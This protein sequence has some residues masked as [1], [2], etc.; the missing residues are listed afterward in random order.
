MKT[1]KGDSESVKKS[2]LP[3]EAAKALGLTQKAL[4]EYTDT[5][6]I[7]L[8]ASKLG[9]SA[10]H[11]SIKEL[12]GELENLNTDL[13]GVKDTLSSYL[14]E[15]ETQNK[16]RE[17]AYNSKKSQLKKAEADR[18]K[19]SKALS[20]TVDLAQKLTEKNE[21]LEA[22]VQSSVSDNQSM[23]EALNASTA[24]LKQAG[25]DNESLKTLIESQQAQ[26]EK[27]NQIIAAQNEIQSFTESKIASLSSEIN[28]LASAVQ[29]F[30]QLMNASNAQLKDDVAK[31]THASIEKYLG[32]MNEKVGKLTSVLAAIKKANEDSAANIEMH[33]TQV[34]EASETAKDVLV[35]FKQVVDGM[36]TLAKEV[37]DSTEAQSKRSAQALAE[38]TT[39]TGTVESRL[40]AILRDAPQDIVD[41]VTPIVNTIS[42]SVD[43]EIVDLK[44]A[45]EKAVNLGFDTLTSDV[46]TRLGFLVNEVNERTSE[47]YE[48]ATKAEDADN[49][50]IL[51][52]LESMASTLQEVSGS[53]AETD[54]LKAKLAEL[55]KNQE[56]ISSMLSE[57]TPDAEGGDV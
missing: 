47:V 44:G 13:S 15:V 7:L 56:M 52:A 14:S 32:G 49:A 8:V 11:E 36:K 12:Q 34:S 51:K 22:Q 41:A 31:A 21:G 17:K 6:L 54:S 35:E 45:I 24:A 18:D 46:E 37:S 50:L 28:F 27:Q 30:P 26:I 20:D 2:N 43:N 4:E 38:F 10:S 29:S 39:Q 9:T 25:Q 55:Q 3:S 42:T 53:I 48:A 5:D 1:I 19:A 57:F 23:V 33:A 40:K 16:E